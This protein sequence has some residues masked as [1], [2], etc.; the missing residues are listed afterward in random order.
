MGRR[1]NAENFDRTILGGTA[2]ITNM[3]EISILYVLSNGRGEGE[4]GMLGVTIF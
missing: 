4:W 3:W 2:R 1:A